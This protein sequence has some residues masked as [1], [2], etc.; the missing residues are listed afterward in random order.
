M[1]NSESLSK[2]QKLDLALKAAGWVVSVLAL[3][4]V[5]YQV[6]NLNKQTERNTTALEAQVWQAVTQQQVEISKVMIQYPE[7]FPYLSEGKVITP[8]DKDFNRVITVADMYLD[9][10]DGFGDKHVRTLSGMEDN[11]KFWVLWEKYFHDLFANSPA[12]CLRYTEVAD[13]YIE[14]VGKYARNSCA[15]VSSHGDR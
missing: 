8:A 5:G 4:A 7:L 9:F 10:I 15:T 1:T 3:G 14:D 2:Y 12:L 13:T 11:G 6:S